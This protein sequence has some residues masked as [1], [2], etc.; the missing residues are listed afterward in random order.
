MTRDFNIRPV[1]LIL[2]WFFLFFFPVPD[3]LA[4]SLEPEIKFD[5]ISI[6]QGLS[7]NVA[8]SIAVDSPGFVWIGA[9]D[10]L[11]RYDGYNFR[12]FRHDPADPNSLSNSFISA[13]HVDRRGDLW[14]GTADGVNRFDSRSETFI[15]YQHDPN[16][17]RS[18]GSNNITVIY[19]DRQG[20]IWIGAGDGGLNRLEPE[21]GDFTRFQHRPD[22][23]SSLSHDRVNAIF[24]DRNGGF[25]IGTGDGLDR[26]DRRTG[27]CVHY[28]NDPADAFSLSDD[29][30]T[31]IYEDSQGALWIGT[32]AGG[33]NRMERGAGRFYSFEPIPGNP[34]SLSHEHVTCIYEDV[35]GVLWI[36]T[37]GGGLSIFDRETGE[38]RNYRNEI[39][40]PHSLPSNIILGIAEDDAGILW[41]ATENGAAKFAP[42]KQKFAHYQHLP[43]VK[44]GLSHDIVSSIYMDRSGVLWVGTLG[45]GLNRFDEETRQFIHYR[46]DPDDPTSIGD[47][48]VYSIFEDSR[49]SLWIGCQSGGLNLFNRDTETF[50]RFTNDP[51]RRD[52]LSHNFVWPILE[53]SQGNLWIGTWGGGLNHFFPET[54]RFV[55]YRHDSADP[56]S[57]SNDLL[58][59]LALEDSG[60]L[61][62]GSFQG[63]NRFD[64]K[65]GVFKKFLHDPKDP[66]SIPN[67]S[68]VSLF[69]DRNGQIWV[70]TLGGL[71][72]FDR[73]T[74][75]FT[76]YS[77]ENGLPSEVVTSIMEDDDGMIW[78]STFNGI[79]RFDPRKEKF[80][81]FDVG[82]GLQSRRYR[83]N[84]HYHSPDG[85][86]FFGGINGFNVFR[87]DRIKEDTYAP[88]VVL[89]DFQIFNR[90]VQPGREGPLRES[91]TLAKDISLT[92]KD[93]VFS[94]E[95]AAL[96]YSNPEVIRYAYML[97]GFDRDWLYTDAR[98]RFATYTNL[99]GGNYTFRVKATNSDGVWSDKTAQLKLHIEPPFWNTSWFYLLMICSALAV[100]ILTAIYLLRL[101]H[102]IRDRKNAEH[103][104]AASEEKYRNLIESTPDLHFRTDPNGKILFVSRSIHKLTGYTVEEAQEMSL[105]SDLY[106]HPED[107]EQYT[108][109]LREKGYVLGFEAEFRRADGSAWW[110]ST[111]AHF[112]RDDNAEI[113]GVEGI[114]RDVT[115][116]KQAE[117]EKERLEAHLQQALK[118]EAVGTLAGG[119]AHDFN[120][121]LSAIIGYS[122]LAKMDVP[123]ESKSSHFLDNILKAGNRAKDLVQQILTFS[124]QTDRQLKPVAVKNVLTEALKLMRASLPSTIEIRTNIQGE[125]LVMGDLTQIHQIIMNLCTNAGQAMQ[126]NGGTLEVGLF[127][128]E[129]DSISTSFYP[130]LKPGVY[131]NL[132]VSDTGCG[133]PPEVL[134]RVFDPFFTTKEQGQGTGMGLAMVHGIVKNFGG[135]ITAYSEPGAGSTFKVLLP[136]TENE[137]VEDDPNTE[138]LPRGDER[139]LF[140]DDEADLAEVGYEMLSALG[141][142][143][144]TQTNSLEAL[145]L[146]RANPEEFDLVITDMTMPR[147]TGLVLAEKMLSIRAG[148]PIILCTGFVSSVTEEIIEKTG[149]KGLLAKPI[150][151]NGIARTVRRILDEN[152]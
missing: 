34:A 108:I 61:W 90:S 124:R 27:D 9:Q 58:A 103:A 24:E 111:N 64:P 8:L 20:T 95:F 14:V 87:P 144:T 98:K 93:S 114:I 49:G 119:I 85:R 132:V 68:V 112:F 48:F 41:F 135:V 1:S 148:I 69:I 74:E 50:E 71:G 36:G 78:L 70:G 152:N 94:F 23:P 47:D 73:D 40:N 100:F 26:M 13:L 44:N 17:P 65:T 138:T 31:A 92:Y 115:K 133:M 89:T 121:I 21:S 117:A 52:S 127:D 128:V 51:D 22:D 62:I 146:F 28:R 56:D 18:L 139:I 33:L 129:L 97:E 76:R 142:R 122:E 131:L 25:W 102:E 43:N 38:F 32:E 63:L 35:R 2:I 30:V 5:V 105:T 101:K 80:T 118:M 84:A 82:D 53:D 57:L 86:M 66:E 42:A 143:V 77:L 16:A 113:L 123:Q 149:V 6:E 150:V 37:H 45:G 72:R 126:E 46:Y 29:N 120:N 109:K 91:I 3:I 79:S 88:N 55:R 130:D 4:F 67:N 12:V 96:H 39:E 99:G 60:V 10:G 19:E 151:T 15:R 110:A 59:C 11:N 136:A 116:R 145:E 141:Y 140:V 83:A 137:L 134:N 125:S 54:D 106:L 7:E 104:L 75:S 81:N 147:M 107:S